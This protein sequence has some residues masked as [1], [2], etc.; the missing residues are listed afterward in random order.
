MR[1]RLVGVKAQGAQGVI[2]HAVDVVLGRDVAIKLIPTRGRNPQAALEEARRLAKF[3]HPRVVRVYDAGVEDDHVFIVMELIDGVPA[4]VFALDS[5]FTAA[6]AARI[7]LQASEGLEA[8]HDAGLVHGDI[9]LRNIVVDRD[10]QVVLVDLGL[11]ASGMALGGTPGFVAPEVTQT[12]CASPQSDQYA[13]GRVLTLLLQHVPGHAQAL[14]RVASKASARAAKSRFS[15]L[16]AMRRSLRLAPARRWGTVALFVCLL[17]LSWTGESPAAQMTRIEDEAFARARDEGFEGASALVRQAEE[18]ALQED[19]QRLL[20]RARLLAARLA[21]SPSKRQASL[22]EAF[23]LAQALDDDKAQAEVLGLSA[24]WAED[25]EDRLLLAN[26]SALLD[27]QGPISALVRAQEGQ[28]VAPMPSNP[29]ASLTLAMVRAADTIEEP[30]APVVPLDCDSIVPRWERGACY[31]VDA[32]A[33]ADKE[34]AQAF[35]HAN[36]AL[37]LLSGVG[38]DDVLCLAYWAR[39]VASLDDDPSAA[40]ADFVEVVGCRTESSDEDVASDN[41]ALAYALVRLGRLEDARALLPM[42]EPWEADLPTTPL[43]FVEGVREAV[44]S[45]AQP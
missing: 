33:L 38:D 13:L 12:S 9:S 7:T 41:A 18:L 43:R 31:A 16:S 37:S 27:P 36:V 20:L 10:G 35:E 39:G 21:E 4:D 17:G 1:Y 40:R 5:R 32:A 22:E 24:S 34:P 19:E 44:N 25:H 42:I 3:A 11:S 8:L 23:A 6:D 14:E 45:G 2:C 26:M 28:P 30:D 15:S 29:Q